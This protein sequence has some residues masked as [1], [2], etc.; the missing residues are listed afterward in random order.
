[1]SYFFSLVLQSVE[2]LLQKLGRITVLIN[3]FVKWTRPILK[4]F[5]EKN[6]RNASDLVL[7]GY[8]DM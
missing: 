4:D 3:W 8:G 1:M 7:S 5:S 6:P 2:L